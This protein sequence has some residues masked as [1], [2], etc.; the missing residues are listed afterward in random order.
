[1]RGCIE[2]CRRF[3]GCPDSAVAIF[4][5]VLESPAI[6]DTVVGRVENNTSPRP[7]NEEALARLRSLFLQ[8]REEVCSRY[9]EWFYRYHADLYVH[10]VP[11]EVYVRKVRG[12]VEALGDATC[13]L[14]VG[15]GF[16]VYSCL[17]RILGVPRVVSM[18]YHREKCRDARAL[19]REL[20]L[21]GVHVVHGDALTFPL[22]RAAVDGGL[23]LACLSHIRDPQAALKDLARALRPGAR[24]YVYEDNNSSYPG[25]EKQ[26]SKQWEAAEAGEGAH[27]DKQLSESFLAM[28][29]EMIQKAFPSMTKDAL[30]HCARETRGLYGKGILEAAEQHQKGGPIRNPRRH[31]V[32]HPVSG[33]FE[34]YPLNPT[35]VLEML[36]SAG[37]ETRL[38]SPHFGPFR[39]RF[40]AFKALAAAAFRV[41]PALLRW[42]SPTFAVVARRLTTTP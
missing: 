4:A 20:G 9:S 12:I 5:G 27:G 32:C 25:Y 36:A 37:F 23:A 39:G 35:L 30:D 42:A 7:V 17:L 38:S 14:D 24:I 21:D 3:R 34:E 31:L 26:M 18:D 2:G 16:G 11:F 10:A 40:S 22:K 15:A 28:R 33:E 19:V 29:R 1:M 6:S 8:S 41:C 13:I